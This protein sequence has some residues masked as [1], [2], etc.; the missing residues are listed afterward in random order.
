MKVRKAISTALFFCL[1]QVNLLGQVKIKQEGITYEITSHNSATVVDCSRKLEGE[2][3]VPSII[4]LDG[5]EYTVKVVARKAFANCGKVTSLTLPNSITEIEAS[6]F[7][8]CGKLQYIK[9]PDKCSIKST[10]YELSPFVGC[11]NLLA[12]AGYEARIPQWVVPQIEKMSSMHI[13]L[14]TKKRLMELFG[15]EENTDTT[16]NTVLESFKSFAQQSV[17]QKMIKWQKKSEFET[18]P[19]YKERMSEE[20]RKRKMQELVNEAKEEYI[21]ANTPADL[22]YTLGTYNADAEVF[23]IIS[24]IKELDTIFVQVPLSEAPQFKSDWKSVK[25]EPTFGVVEDKFNLLA[26]EAVWKGKNYKSTKHAIDTSSDLAISL[27]PLEIVI[28]EGRTGTTE[29]PVDR[30]VDEKIPTTSI[31]NS[32]TFAVVIGNEEYKKASKVAYAQ[33]DAKIFAEY[34]KK[35]LGLPQK[36]IHYHENLSYGDMFTAIEDIR[37]IANSKHGDINIIFYYAGH[38]VPDEETKDA[39]LLPVDADGRQVEVCY[40]LKRLYKDLEEMNAHQ[41]TVF[42]DACFSGS[43]RGNG[44]LANA[45]GVAIKPREVNPKGKMVVFAATQGDETAWPYAEKGHG[46]FTYFLLKKLQETKGNCTLEDLHTYIKENVSQES[47]VTNKRSQ[48][49][50]LTPSVSVGDSWKEWK[51]K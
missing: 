48:T 9:L 22:A 12:V 13:N 41:T 23:P 28:D 45:R 6:A 33:N 36:N 24:N 38:G 29:K 18:T 47:S 21:K 15:E 2:V 1:C 31:T 5:K 3:I 20:N 46:L 34:C 44:M 43:I 16:K 42:I 8:Y 30:S 7:E 37:R 51:L 10:W 40:S 49:P 19:Q 50:T 32:R 11:N 39:Y 27:P 17:K 25:I 35:T 26:C 14:K 4:T